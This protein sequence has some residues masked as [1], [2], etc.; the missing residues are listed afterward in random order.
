MDDSRGSLGWAPLRARRCLPSPSRA[1]RSALRPW[2]STRYATWS[3]A[4]S[5]S[6]PRTQS[7][8][9]WIGACRCS[10]PG[11]RPYPWSPFSLASGGGRR[12]SRDPSSGPPQPCPRSSGAPEPPPFRPTRWIRSSSSTRCRPPSVEAARVPSRASTRSRDTFLRRWP[13]GPTCSGTRA[14]TRPESRSGAAKSSRTSGAGATPRD[15]WRSLSS[16]G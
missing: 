4:G 5:S 3:S 1:Q 14:S 2:D 9:S 16:T 13:S 10:T 11:M 12:T 8:T 6:R 15:G 7:C